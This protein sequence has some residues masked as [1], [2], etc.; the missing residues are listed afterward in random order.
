MKKNPSPDTFAIR[1]KRLLLEADLSAYRLAQLAELPHQ[2]VQRY[3]SGKR[4]PK[5]ANAVRLARAL[6]LSVEIFADT[7]PKENNHDP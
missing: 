3:L 1:L 7:V 5:F 6:G 4:E 2:T